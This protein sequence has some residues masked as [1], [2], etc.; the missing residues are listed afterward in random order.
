MADGNIFFDFSRLKY[1]GENV[2]IG[3]TVR[4]RYTVSIQVERSC[5]LTSPAFF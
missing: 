3:K 2:I 1:L 5:I 4:I